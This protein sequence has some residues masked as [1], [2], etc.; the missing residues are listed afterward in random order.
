[1]I[2]RESISEIK[3]PCVANCCLDEDDIC[4]GCFRALNEILDWSEASDERRTEII[5]SAAERSQLHQEKYKR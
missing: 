4:L 2:N 3:S 5:S 1:M